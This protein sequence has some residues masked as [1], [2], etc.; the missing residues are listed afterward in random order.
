MDIRAGQILSDTFA[1]IRRHLWPLLLASLIFAVPP[2]I[3]IKLIN[4]EMSFG[5]QNAVSL[6]FTIAASLA[7]VAIGL[8]GHEAPL[9]LGAAWQRSGKY[10]G[11]YFAQSWA[12]GLATV[13]GLVLLIVPGLFLI[14]VL[15][16]AGPVVVAEGTGGID[17]LGRS[18]A[19][20]R[21][22]FWP[23][24]GALAALIGVCVVPA[25]LLI[26]AVS[27][28]PMNVDMDIAAN[29]SLFSL[30]WGLELTTSLV[31]GAGI[32]ALVVGTAVL[33]R[34]LTGSTINTAVA[35][36]FN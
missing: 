28:L 33:Y 8:Y 31:I 34:H 26:V 19:L 32:V 21:G 3:I 5:L 16:V 11:A 12:G 13:L 24:A 15:C 36:V 14:V 1:I 20:V 35:D 10:F 29:N 23:V 4:P 9:S 30:G 17:S 2:D 25:L 22:R 7:A 18:R 6:P 27:I